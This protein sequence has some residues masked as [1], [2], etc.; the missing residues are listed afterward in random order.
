MP[1]YTQVPD[2]LFDT[3]M[4]HLSGAELKVLLYIIRRTF[5]FKKKR[6]AISLSQMVSGIKTKSG[7]V[8]DRGTG[9]GRS[10]VTRALN[11][12]EEMQVIERVRRHSHH[13]GDEP[14][15]YALK[16]LKTLSQNETPPGIK[17]GH[18]VSLP[19]DTQHTARQQTE[20][21]KAA[22]ADALLNFGIDKPTVDRIVNNQEAELI[23]QKID[24][25]VFM[26]EEQP[27]L[28]RNPR[29]WLLKAIEHDFGPPAGYRPRA[30]REE[31]RV[32]AEKQQKEAEESEMIRQQ[33]T[34]ETRRLHQAE[35]ERLIASAQEA[36]QTTAAEEKLWQNVL[37][38][39]R[40][41][42]SDMTYTLI[43]DA[44]LLTTNDGTAIIGTVNQFS[45]HWLRNHLG[46]DLP[47]IFERCG[48][49]VEAIQVLH[50]TPK[51]H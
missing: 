36:Y 15:T 39:L 2:E 43:K 6:D 12:L 45:V 37:H 4:P 7:E 27:N 50:L 25:V 8:L 24:Y 5:G 21:Q 44:Q 19:T 16:M 46:T 26:L 17:M 31:I 10:S 47:A 13:R 9:L 18:P 28:V 33:A 29:G 40:P 35:K 48:Q 34:E 23:A 30:E 20:E 22:L 38:R 42:T 32:C 1:N 49:P 14:T 41:L 51:E 11:S 3:L